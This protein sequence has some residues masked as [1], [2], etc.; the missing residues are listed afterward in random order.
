M[1][2][3]VIMKYKID[4]KSYSA[5]MGFSLYCLVAMFGDLIIQVL[6]EYV[7]YFLM[8]VS[9]FLMIYA[10]S[11]EWKIRISNKILLCL[12]PW[13]LFTIGYICI[14]NRSIF[15]GSFYTT[16][17]WLYFFSVIFLISLIDCKIYSKLLKILMFFSLI[18]VVG[19]YFFMLFPDKYSVMYN[20]WGYWPTG[21]N[22]GMS[23]FHAGFANHYSENAMYIIPCLFICISKFLT[24]YRKKKIIYLFG[25]IVSGFA[26]IATAKRAH[27]LF[28]AIAFMIAYYFFDRRKKMSRFFKLLVVIVTVFAILNILSLFV[29]TIN[30]LFERFANIGVDQES[31]TRFK[32]WK[33]AIDNFKKSPLFGIGWFGYKYQYN[34]MLFDPLRRAERYGY[35]NS[36]NVYLQLLCETGILGFGL[37]IWGGINIFKETFNLLDEEIIDG[38]NIKEI[39]FFSLIMQLFFWLYSLTGNCLYDTMFSFYTFASG[40]MM[41]CII[42]KSKLR[43][44]S[45]EKDCNI[46]I[47]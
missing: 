18:Y 36:H 27:V 10:C 17:R 9:L 2:K 45:Y 31:N 19:V 34:I 40:L 6:P 38:Y 39:L 30:M 8:I 7:R 33:L 22:N 43:R 37:I 44:L 35:L 32:M 12:M 1:N 29:P 15:K 28:G 24:E 14:Y 4:F 42:S 46:N 13:I 11:I 3:D 20:I 16:I 21:T 25:I 41:G 5:L 47:S 23:G 26:L